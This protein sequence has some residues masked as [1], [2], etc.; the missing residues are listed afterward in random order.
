M[1]WPDDNPLRQVVT[2]TWTM[3]ENNADFLAL[4]PQVG[5]RIKYIG[6]NLAP[7]KN[8]VLTAD[9]PTTR[10]VA[11]QFLPRPHNTS[12]SSGLDVVYEIQVAQGE[13]WL[14]P[15]LDI[16]FAVY[17]ALS[18]WRETMHALTW[19]GNQFVTCAKPVEVEPISLDNQKLNRG[20]R[21]WSA[22]WRG[23]IQMD[24]PTADL[25]GG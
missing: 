18:P 17:R 25:E 11:V 5:N 15:L 16:S 8:E 2:A 3:L 14:Q 10:I 13:Q 4:V 9:F 7:E 12:D 20:I 6:S 22:V 24:F 23:L 21:G 1:A 19:E